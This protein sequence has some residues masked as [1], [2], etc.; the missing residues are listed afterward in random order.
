V[1]S[2]ARLVHGQGRLLF[3]QNGEASIAPT[4]RYYD[5]WN[6]EDVSSTYDFGAKRYV[7]QPAS[8][9]R[10]ADAALRRI[11]ARGLLALA[12]DYVAAGDA[13]G[14]RDA[15]ANACAAGALPFVSDI[16]LTRV[17]AAPARCGR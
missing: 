17:P 10:A 15:V 5:G 8:A 1:R 16:G 7:R 3:T 2:L 13:T 9:I 6:R 14:T 12:T 11:A 4:L